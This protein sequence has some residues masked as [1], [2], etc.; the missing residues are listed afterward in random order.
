MFLLIAP[1]FVLVKKFQ[2]SY[3]IFGSF[4]NKHC[5]KPLQEA[6]TVFSLKLLKVHSYTLFPKEILAYVYAWDA[7]A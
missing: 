2:C 4:H 1:I 6:L 7:H 3:F 5:S